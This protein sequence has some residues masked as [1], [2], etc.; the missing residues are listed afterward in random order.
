MLNNFLKFRSVVVK[1]CYSVHIFNN[2][3]VLTYFKVF[4][5]HSTATSEQSACNI[6]F[7]YIDS[8]N[9][10][11]IADN[12]IAIYRCIFKGNISCTSNNDTLKISTI[13]TCRCYIGFDSVI[14]N[15]CKLF[16]GNVCFRV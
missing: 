9:A 15:L 2:N 5:G 11:A 4:Q 1:L 12:Q 6:S 3:E 16:T 8:S 10:C 14:H 13:N 7:F